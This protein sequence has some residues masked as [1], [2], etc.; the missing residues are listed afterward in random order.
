MVFF[1]LGREKPNSYQHHVDTTGNA[2]VSVLTS[3]KGMKTEAVSDITYRDRIGI[4]C[5][6][7]L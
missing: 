3:S 6:G 1:S 7:R 4:S 2:D 5:L